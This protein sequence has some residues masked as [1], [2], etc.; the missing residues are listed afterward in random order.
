MHIY[1]THAHTHNEYKS[2]HVIKFYGSI[3][4]IVYIVIILKIIAKIN[5]SLW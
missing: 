2:K 3:P 1:N 4:V 5:C